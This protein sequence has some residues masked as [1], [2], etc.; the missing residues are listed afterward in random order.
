[1]RE[2][3]AQTAGAAKLGPGTLYGSIKTLLEEGLIEELGD[4]EAPDLGDERRRYYRLTSAGRKRASDEASRMAA[5][6]RVA[7][8]RRILRG[9]HV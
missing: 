3:E 8:N 6:L 7:R 2:V 5:V 1:M 9:A 4:R